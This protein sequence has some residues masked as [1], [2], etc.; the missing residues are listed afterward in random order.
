MRL[1][2]RIRFLSFASCF[3]VIA[4]FIQR[5]T[6]FAF[7]AHAVLG[8]CWHHSHGVCNDCCAVYANACADVETVGHD[9]ANHECC[10]EGSEHSHRTESHFDRGV[11]SIEAICC[12]GSN[13]D[14]HDCNEAR[15]SYVTVKLQ[16]F[17]FQPIARVVE[18]VHW[19]SHRFA[20]TGGLS[21]HRPFAPFPRLFALTSG[22]RCADLQSWQI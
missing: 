13:G 10:S 4:R 9:H 11:T 5:L 7:A 21:A 18:S 6:L 3:A 17:D 1:S 2:V 8:C 22:H 16:T 19:D 15:C 12:D 20:A 14:S